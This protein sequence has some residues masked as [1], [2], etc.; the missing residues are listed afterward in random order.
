[1]SRSDDSHSAGEG[2]PTSARHHPER[3]VFTTFVALHRGL[4]FGRKLTLAERRCLAVIDAQPTGFLTVD[5]LLDRDRTMCAWECFRKRVDRRKR[6][7]APLVYVATASKGV[8]KGGY[9]LHALL[10]EYLPKRVWIGA[11]KGAGFGGGR[12]DSIATYRERPIDA[13][14]QVAYLFRQH[15]EVFGKTYAH[16]HAGRARG[17][18]RLLRPQKRTLQRHCPRLFAALEAANDASLQDKDLVD[19]LP[20]FSRSRR[21]TTSG[22]AQGVGPARQSSPAHESDVDDR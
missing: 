11:L 19:A 1:M 13:M 22:L 9:H 12:I 5:S 14:Q 18:W 7:R 21:S 4:P 15:E 3:D 8:G 2:R 16:R 6:A 17:S 10:W 20:L